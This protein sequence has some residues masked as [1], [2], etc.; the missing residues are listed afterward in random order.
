MSQAD[1]LTMV[2]GVFLGNMASFA[3]IFCIWSMCRSE[4]AGKRT[5][6]LVLFGIGLPLLLAAL[7]LAT[8]S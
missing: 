6:P 2:L 1:I 3:V 5:S 8:A 4:N 7:V